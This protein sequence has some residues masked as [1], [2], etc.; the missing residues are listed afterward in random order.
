MVIKR[1]LYGI[2]LIGCLLVIQQQNIVLRREEHE[3]HRHTRQRYQL[4]VLCTLQDPLVV[5]L[6]IGERTVARLI[7]L[8]IEVVQPAV[9][10]HLQ[11]LIAK[12]IADILAP[13]EI[14]QCVLRILLGERFVE[15]VEVP[16]GLGD[17][18]LF[19]LIGAHALTKSL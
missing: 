5:A 9:D 15:I 4:H 13:V 2:V 11:I 17:I 1:A 7:R 10:E 8:C 12:H 19:V 16:E 14:L 18:H 6:V 3:V